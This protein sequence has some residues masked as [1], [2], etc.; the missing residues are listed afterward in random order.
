M[1][2]DKYSNDRSVLQHLQ[3]KLTTGPNVECQQKT[4]RSQ[5]W[6]AV[7]A[8]TAWLNGA[9]DFPAPSLPSRHSQSLLG[10]VAPS[11]RARQPVSVRER[12][13]AE[14][15]LGTC[16]IHMHRYGTKTSTKER[17]QVPSVPTC[18]QS[19]IDGNTTPY[20]FP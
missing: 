18:F 8:S 20:T 19:I 6:G 3:P 16:I 17:P 2:G 15:Y 9:G 1:W 11:L 14:V 4:Q 12:E 5:R 7:A 13:G 10:K